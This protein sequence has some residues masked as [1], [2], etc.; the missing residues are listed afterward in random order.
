MNSVIKLTGSAASFLAKIM[1]F[2]VLLGTA[3]C[4]LFYRVYPLTVIT[5]EIVT[6]CAVLGLA[7]C[8]VAVGVWKKIAR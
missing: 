3:Y 8:L 5:S 1:V 7:T 6:L 4:V 2:S